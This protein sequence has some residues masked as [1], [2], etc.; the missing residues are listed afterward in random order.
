MTDPPDGSPSLGDI[1]IARGWKQ[2]A[3]LSA[4]HFTF[5]WNGADAPGSDGMVTPRTRRLRAKERLVVATQTCDIQAREQDEPYLE[6]LIC[7]HENPRFVERVLERS[8]RWFV[9]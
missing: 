4:P 9:I 1:L 2:G 3:L 5:S 6:T 7:R 8:A